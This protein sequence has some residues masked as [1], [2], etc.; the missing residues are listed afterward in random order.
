[1]ATALETRPSGDEVDPRMRARRAQ[2]ER[3][4]HRR[5][6]RRTFGVLAAATLLTGAWALT[7][8]ALLDVDRIAVVG[9]THLSADEVIAASGVRPGEQLLDVHAGPIRS[10]LRELPWV[11][12]AQVDRSW[13]GD[14]VLRIDERIPV[15]M[16]TDASGRA[17]L[18]DRDGHVLAPAGLPDP[19][20]VAVAGIPAGD[21]GSV[22]G[23]AQDALAVVTALTPGVRSRIQTLT[24]MPDGQIQFAVQP[25]GTVL[26]C[27]ATDIDAKV[28]SLQ[29]MFAQV[30]DRDLQTLS[31]CNPDQPTIVRTAH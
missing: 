4:R 31:V 15:A 3:A 13:R 7:R 24:V 12:D 28:R 26:F 17:M 29:T 1:M 8:T 27:D 16:F 23:G 5:R 19:N 14:V 2:V 30:D 20:L 18:V 25:S 22:V 6:R 21:P 11:A 9:S 10:R